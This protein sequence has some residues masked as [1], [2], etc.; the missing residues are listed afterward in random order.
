MA[1]T[2]VDTPSV[3]VCFCML[4]FDNEMS[5]NME[6]EDSLRNEIILSLPYYS[7][8]RSILFHGIL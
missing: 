6:S 7:P 5:R 1:S 3:C 2:F 4:C 8:F